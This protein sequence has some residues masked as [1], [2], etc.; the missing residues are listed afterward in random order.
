M[1]FFASREKTKQEVNEM[2]YQIIN[3]GKENIGIVWQNIGGKPQIE[4]IFL[5]C[6][7]S[8]IIAA[9][10][11]EFP[12]VN[13]K[14]QKIPGKIATQI[15]EFYAGN[16]VKFDTSLLNMKKLSGFSAKVLKQ[17]CKIPHGKVTTYSGL[18]VKI[19]SPRAARAVGTALANNPFPLV[20]PCHRVVRSDGSLGGFGGGINMKK[21]LLTREG[22][23]R[24]KNNLEYKS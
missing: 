9:I 20:I 19:G 12:A 11:K 2:Y 18:A 1:V 4:R 10:K 8:K 6:L 7:K 22:A 14:E 15:A 17:T 24:L 5:P 3:I 16:K 21:E 23:K 13:K